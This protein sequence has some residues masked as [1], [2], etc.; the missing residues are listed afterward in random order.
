MIQEEG[1][2]QTSVIT[3]INTNSLQSTDRQKKNALKTILGSS[4]SVCNIPL[5]FFF[6]FGSHITQFAYLISTID[7]GLHFFPHVLLVVS[8]HQGKRIKQMS[9]EQLY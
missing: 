8:A 2:V 4:F 7:K 1:P 3:A 9:P 6:F 5:I